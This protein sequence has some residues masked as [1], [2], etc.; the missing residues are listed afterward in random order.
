MIDKPAVLDHYR[1]QLAELAARPDPDPRDIAVRVA[2]L[3]AR[4]QPDPL[5]DDD[6]WIHPKVDR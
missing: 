4:T 1:R 6:A 5:P 3:A 2:S